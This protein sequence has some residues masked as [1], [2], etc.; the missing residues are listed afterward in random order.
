MPFNY[1]PLLKLLIDRDMT[2]EELRKTVKA[3]PTS[4]AR[5]GKNENVSMDLLDRIC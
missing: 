2:R 4:F 1:K 5:I 3:G